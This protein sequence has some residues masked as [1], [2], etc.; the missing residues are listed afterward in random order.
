MRLGCSVRQLLE[1][2]TCKLSG[3][4]GDNLTKEV[5]R[6][7]LVPETSHR[8]AS[9]MESDF[10]IEHGG[11]Q[12]AQKLVSHS[13]KS[14][15]AL[16]VLNTVFDA[17]GLTKGEFE[18]QFMDAKSFKTWYISQD[19]PTNKSFFRRL[20]EALCNSE[21]P[22][23]Q[24]ALDTRYWLCVF[25][26]NQHKAVCGRCYKHASCRNLR[27]PDG[28]K[29]TKE[30]YAAERCPHG[31]EKDFPCD[32]GTLKP[33]R[34]DPDFEM[35]KFSCVANEMDGLVVSLDDDLE[36][37]TRVWVLREIWQVTA[38]P[39]SVGSG[40]S[41]KSVRSGAVQFRTLAELTKRVNME[42]EAGNCIPV[43]EKCQASDEADK[44]R[45]LKEIDDSPGGRRAFQTLLRCTV[46]LSF[47]KC[48]ALTD[49]S[50]LTRTLTYL[51]MNCEW[52]SGD[53]HSTAQ[54]KMD[55]IRTLRA[56]A[57]LYIRFPG[58]NRLVNLE[59][60]AAG[61][62]H[63]TNLTTLRLEFEDCTLLHSVDDVA[64]ALTCVTHLVFLDLRL[65]GC[66]AL[67]SVDQVG[68]ALRALTNLSSLNLSFIRCEGLETVAE[69]GR[70][71]RDLS[72]LT[73]LGINF[74]E[75]TGLSS[76]DEVGK[77]IACLRQLTSLNLNFFGCK[78]L[79]RV[80][81]VGRA[82]THLSRLAS[83]ELHLSWCTRLQSVDA[84]G[85]GLPH[86][87]NVRRLHLRFS[88]SAGLRNVDEIGKGLQHL[89]QLASLNLYF[90]QCRG[91]RSVDEVR[92]ALTHLTQLKSLNMSFTGCTGLQGID[93]AVTYLESC[94]CKV[95]R[96]R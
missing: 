66:T 43:L 87:A 5:V 94:G 69:V 15:F 60:L 57:S 22:T 46:E 53:L 41:S 11:P 28:Q 3:L 21:E 80:D 6:E 10:M 58:C 36:T 90:T 44:E 89:D 48:S 84:I 61:L 78:G 39:R 14:P 26:V 7:V 59:A 56:L 83:L 32:C 50:D 2:C 67:H 47:G 35:D 64:K 18:E 27:R 91:L 77:G 76:V 70:G 82:L 95:Q 42:M 54:L 4:F 68:K 34:G 38:K 1:F 72:Q 13:W 49:C 45:I 73:N 29:W 20:H 25:A 85:Q 62:K 12:R 88:D 31:S 75:C 16:T 52:K 79:H 74:S 23:I 55:Q 30:D 17:T 33:E 19:R 86:L 71:L 81:H 63:L 40:E 8:P 96:L 37:L 93:S 65:H 9:Y 24:E 92:K 51:E